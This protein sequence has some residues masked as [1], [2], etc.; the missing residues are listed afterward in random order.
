MDFSLATFEFL[1]VYSFF[2]ALSKN[3]L[4]N[5]IGVGDASHS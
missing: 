4:N 3:Q 1:A 5:E 2:G